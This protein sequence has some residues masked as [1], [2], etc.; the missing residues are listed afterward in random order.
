MK[1][2]NVTLFT[3]AGCTLCDK[4]KAA[5]RA[6]GVRVRLA[7][8]DVDADPELRRRYTND[9]PVI[10]IDGRDV[11]RHTV[12]AERFRAYIEGERQ[13]MT[14]LATEKCVPCRGGVPP[15]AGEELAELARELGGGWNV[16]DGHHLEKEFRFRDFAEALAFTNRVGAI[17]EEEGHHPDIVLAWGKVRITTWTHKIDGLTRSDF[18]LAAKIDALPNPAAQ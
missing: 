15:L 9:V 4:A 16:V 11:F 7:E 12:D 3:R 18:V 13:P 5:I 17:A 2:V 6:S 14:A 10:R 1:P 8:V